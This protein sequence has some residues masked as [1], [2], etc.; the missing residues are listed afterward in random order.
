MTCI[1]PNQMSVSYNSPNQMSTRYNYP[2][3]TPSLNKFQSMQFSNF[4]QTEKIIGEM[5]DDVKKRIFH[6]FKD[7]SRSEIVALIVL[8]VLHPSDLT[9]IVR[10]AEEAG[11]KVSDLVLAMIKNYKENDSNGPTANILFG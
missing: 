6:I 3:Q 10:D 9:S 8:G 7:Q 5:S 11:I 2:Q 4:S 1:S